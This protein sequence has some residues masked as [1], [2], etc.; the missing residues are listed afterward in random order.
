MLNFSTLIRNLAQRIGKNSPVI[1]LLALAVLMVAPSPSS[2]QTGTLTDDATYPTSFPPKSLT[3]QGSSATGGAATSFVKFKLTPNLPTGA[4]GSFVWKATLRLYVANVTTAGSFNVYRVTSAWSES[5]TTAPTYDSTSPVATGVAV[6]SAAAFVTIDLSSLVQQWLGTDGLGTGGVPNYGVALVANTTN[7]AFNF[8]SKE[9]TTTSH[10]AHLE[11]V[12]NHALTADTATNFSGPLAGD[13]TGTQNATVVSSVG[14]RSA[15]S[16]GMATD[17]ANAATS[18]ST[19]GA[20]VR[21][22]ASGNFSAGT[23]TA[24]LN[25]NASSANNATNFT[26]NLSGDVT[27]PQGATVV[28]SV[29]GKSA[30]SVASAT[31][32]ANSAASTNTANAIVKRDASGNFSAGT[33]T[34]S[35]NGD[36]T[37]ATTAAS[38]N[39]LANTATIGGNQVS[40]DL[41]KATIAGNRVNGAVAN[42][43]NATIASSL[44][45]PAT[46]NGSG[47]VLT[48]NSNNGIGIVSTGALT[49]VSGTGVYVGVYAKA[50]YTGV[51]ATSSDTGVSAFGNIKGVAG[52]GNTGIAGFGNT[53]V[54]TTPAG[55][56]VYGRGNTVAGVYGVGENS[57]AGVYGTVTGSGP[58]GLFDGNVTV[59]GNLNVSGSTNISPSVNHDSTLSGNGSAG[60]PLAVVSAPNGVVTTGSYANPAWITSLDGSKISGRVANAATADSATSLTGVLPIANGGTGSG[61]QNFVDLSTNQTIN[62]NK[63]F[64]GAINTSTQYNIGDSRVLSTTGTNN[65]FVGVGAGQNN[66]APDGAF[67]GAFAGQANTVGLRNSFFGSN[68]ARVN[69]NGGDNAFFGFGTGQFNTNGSNNVFF[70]AFAG[71][72]NTTGQ[73]NSFVGSNA[74]ISNTTGVNNSFFGLAAGRHNGTGSNNAFFGY[75]AGEQTT[76]GDNA[77][78]GGSA[79]EANTAGLRNSFFGSSAGLSN[80][81]ENKNTFIGAFSNG[82]PGITNAT[83]IGAD[84]V[85][86]QSNSIV[87]GNNASVGIGTTTPQA[88]FH[89]VNTGATAGQ[90]DGNVTV[91]GNLTVN[92]NSNVSASVNHDS[93]LSGNGSTESPLAVVSAP[94]GV[95]TT[96][97]YADPAWITSL[98]ANK[99]TGQVV[100]SLNGLSGNVTLAA[101]ENVAITPLG[102][103]LTISSMSVAPPNALQ[104]ATLHWYSAST[105]ATFDVPGNLAGI[106]FDGSN[107]WVALDS[108]ANGNQ[109]SKVRT[110]DGTVVATFTAG[111]PGSWPYGI[112][113]DGANIWVAGERGGVTKLRASDGIEIGTYPAGNGPRRLAFDG[114]SIWVANWE[115][116]TVTKLRASDGAT[117]GTYSVGINPHGVAF[118]GTHIWV[119]SEGGTVTKLRATDGTTLGTYSVGCGANDVTFDGNNMWVVTECG[120]VR[121]LRA[122]DGACVGNSCTFTLGNTPLIGVVFDGT[123]IWVTRRYDGVVTKLR[124]TDGFVLANVTSTTPYAIAFDGAFVW[125]TN[126]TVGRVSKY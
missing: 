81:T 74:G 125:V 78:F 6:S 41:T 59:N 38:A 106:A 66:T 36:A 61:V 115:D 113:F 25:G 99:I 21:R 4:P 55:T 116:G 33:I 45:V 30:A 39:A 13:V 85:V 80:T 73:N 104:L 2:A 101:G 67:F 70:G 1:A 58:A 121:K 50:N 43:T 105:N 27:G 29:G 122:T 18:V 103:T 10:L 95:V 84:A 56:G 34:A 93:T 83:A 54:V 68:S 112:A 8:D 75:L 65:V 119:T 102:N 71:Q 114:S 107:M 5:S 12:L 20:I 64:S 53:A 110:S 47:D 126:S 98:G 16:V 11:I 124:A 44:S 32:A 57:G 49:G 22:D 90:F 89:V 23:I 82:V 24:N 86:A 9:A 100:N 63:T 77:F 17:S 51:S 108:A 72:N 118:D 91:N 123:S 87:L 48:V 19:G 40:G 37:S 111:P 69:T 46:L 3:V 28:S 7:S 109:V 88:K 42:A 92:G 117:E 14:G 60:S 35:L 31:D 96:G 52:S 79:G 62:G 15:T 120:T 97:S 76:S 94:N 26:G